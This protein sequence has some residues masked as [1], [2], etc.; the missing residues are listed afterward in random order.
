MTDLS[1]FGS[2]GLPLVHS[3]MDVLELTRTN[4]TFDEWAKF[5]KSNAAV[6]QWR[7]FLSADPY[8]RWG[9]LKPKGYPGD[10]TLMDLAY[11]HT[12]VKA[13]IDE[14]GVLGREIYKYTSAAKQS[15][16][17]RLRVQLLSD[18]LAQLAGTTVG[19]GV[20]SFASGHARE[21]ELLSP[22]V[23]E[24]LGQ[25]TAIDLDGESLK[26]AQSSALGMP[27]LSA[28][29]NVIT[30]D[31]SD[32]QPAGFVYSLGLFDYLTDYFAQRALQKMW[33]LTKSGGCLVV[34]NLAPDAANIGYCE[35]IM[36]W[37]MVTRNTDQMQ[38]LGDYLNETE[39]EI[40]AITVTRH[41][42]FNYLEITRNT[43][44][45]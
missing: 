40:S 21:L 29:R 33:L 32:L 5:V 27:F 19:S 12:S 15:E 8:T 37:W 41:G 13:L 9:L 22:N 30:A 43:N 17:A 28:Q 18:R 24:K 3:F 42:C 38:A 11:G 14:S 7:F 35:A 25:F 36:D 20:V 10:A 34:A 26:V 16:S 4:L 31:V 45:E 2:P 6:R 23:K 39:P 1:A 44:V